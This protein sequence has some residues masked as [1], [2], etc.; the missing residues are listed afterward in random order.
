MR[1][2]KLTLT[3]FGPYANTQV[4]DFHVLGE[5]SFFL[6]HGATGAGKTMILD[7]ICFA[8][9]G[10]TSGNERKGEH[11]RSHHAKPTTPT[12][13]TFEFALGS[14]VYRV[15]RSLKREPTKEADGEVAYKPDRAVLGRSTD[16][17]KE[18]TMWVEIA[19]KWT[20]VTKAIESLFGFESSQF[21]QVIMLPQDKFQQLLKANSHEREDLFK[22]LFQTEQFE[23]IEQALKEEAKHLEDEL[24]TLTE[25]REWV[26]RM[27]Q[28]STPSE[29]AD[30]RQTTFRSL[31]A[32]RD[33][34]ADLHTIEQQAA[35][36]LSRGKETHRIILEREQAEAD[37]LN[38]ESRQAEFKEKRRS[39][40]RARRAAVLAEL[41]KMALQQHRDAND[42]EVKRDIARTDW[43]KAVESQRLAAD[44]LAREMQRQGE[45]D[46]TRREQ[47]RLLSLHGQVQQL[48]VARQ[49]LKSAQAQKDKATRER[50]DTQKRRD[51]LQAQLTQLQANLAQA[52]QVAVQVISA[53]QSEANARQ[54]HEQ[55]IKLRG[56]AQQWRAA[57]DKEAETQQHLQDTDDKLAQARDKHDAIEAAW[58]EGQAAILARQLADNA[59]CPVCGS[60]HH[61]RPAISDQTPPSEIELKDARAKVTSL[62]AQ[63][64]TMHTEWTRCH[65]DVVRFDAER[66]PLI[67]ELGEK[68]RLPFKQIEAKLEATQGMLRKAQQEAERVAKLKQQVEPLKNQL[69]QAEATL[70]DAEHAWQEAVNQQTTAQAILSERHGNIPPELDDS[71]KLKIAKQRADMRITQLDQALQQ[72]QAE[73]EHTKQHLTACKATFSQLSEQATVTRQRTDELRLQFTGRVNAE[74]FADVDDYQHAKL[75]PQDIAHLDNEIRAYEG[76]LQAASERAERAGKAAESLAK[77]DLAALQA[78]YQQA[79]E[80]ADTTLQSERDLAS[81][82][83]NCDE[84]LEQLAQLQG[85]FTHKENEFRIVGKIAEVANGKNPHNITFQ[86]FVLSALL[87]DVLSDATQRL[88]IMSRGRY[89]LQRA[90]SP[91]DKRK[92]SGLDLVVSDTWTGDSKRP[93]ETLSGGEGFYTSLALALGLAEVVQA[94]AGGIRLDT[95]FIDEGFGSLD[96]DTLDLAIRTLENLKEGGRLV[97]IISHVE[98]LRERIP[99]RLEVTAGVNGSTAKFVTG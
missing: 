96:S 42:A 48:D 88:Q 66:K 63:R 25:Q 4:I 11:M 75:R 23:R 24:E 99:I 44:A 73:D 12:E 31:Q 58:H 6:V 26:L 97:G 85:E 29:L 54:V 84:W 3:A 27:A 39:L 9:Y 46:D 92:A 21:R 19:S 95:V 65:D 69:V 70:A 34:L 47:E 30:K 87:D 37:L 56:V 71:H 62:E 36:Q 41:E 33:K 28:V 61:P 53:Q 14:D 17:E 55:W 89:L 18:Q 78:Q 8:L 82:L 22:I 79:R 52:E 50:T 72:A 59:P 38:L 76:Q 64:Q 86:R 68:A 98:S 32:M 81:Q 67:D 45:R 91:L 1:P 83:K 93:V 90:Q 10:E 5:R 13:V 20:K 40:E 16:I 15:S 2:L 60:I 77:P 57:K 35:E 74:G 49:N 7:A 94:Y 43:E 80:E 51:E